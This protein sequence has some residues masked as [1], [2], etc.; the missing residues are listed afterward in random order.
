M[1]NGPGRYKLGQERNSWQWVKPVWLHSDLLLALKG[2]HLSALVPQQS[3][4]FC[5]HSVPPWGTFF[6]NSQGVIVPH[7]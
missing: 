6:V 2:E 1:V 4:N 7:E 5:I 3:L